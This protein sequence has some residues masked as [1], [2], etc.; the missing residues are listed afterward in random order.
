MKLITIGKGKSI[1]QYN[2]V[3][4][5]YCKIMKTEEATNIGIITLLSKRNIR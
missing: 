3:S 4:A 2:S 1:E 5:S